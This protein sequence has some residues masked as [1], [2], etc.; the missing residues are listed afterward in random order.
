MREKLTRF[1]IGRYGQFDFLSKTI[2]GF[3]LLAL[4]L[5]LL[6]GKTAFTLSAFVLIA[7]LYFRLFSRNIYRR[8]LENQWLLDKTS[9]LRHWVNRQ[10]KHFKEL[11]LYHIYKCPNCRQKIRIPRGKGKIQISCPKCRTTF[12]KNS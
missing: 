9:G 1:M 6:S 2:M 11:K 12:I 5:S 4:A 7:W 8:S 3:G 10:T